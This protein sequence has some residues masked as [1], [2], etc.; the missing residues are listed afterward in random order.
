MLSNEGVHCCTIKVPRAGHLG[1]P[2]L[3]RRAC[4]PIHRRCLPQ[5]GDCQDEWPE[6][7]LWRS[8]LHREGRLR[9]DPGG[10]AD[11]RAVRRGHHVHQGYV[12]HRSAAARRRNVLRARHPAIAAA[13]FRQGWILDRGD[14]A[15]RHPALRVSKRHKGA[16][17]SAASSI[18]M[19]SSV[20][21][22]E[23]SRM[24]LA[25]SLQM[26]RPMN[27]T[28]AACRL[29]RLL[30]LVMP[31]VSGCRYVRSSRSMKTR[32]FG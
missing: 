9:A 31:A 2:P 15:T 5:S 17:P 27:A 19:D 11:R 29:R 21:S 32:P 25:A 12:S 26:L 16:R 22:T 3:S 14:P 6:W 30:F 13:R 1:G 4:R 8:R 18:A 24:D 23:P 28:A 20:V 10:G 7:Q